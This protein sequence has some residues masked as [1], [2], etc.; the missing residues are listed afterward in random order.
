MK[1]YDPKQE[2]KHITNLDANKFYGY[3]MFKF[4]STSGFKCI[5]PKEFG[6]SKYTS[7]SSR[8]YVHE[9]N[10]KYPKELRNYTMIIC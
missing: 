10:L 7:N 4:L 6:L 5:N 9:V 1:S 8:R 3:A 2:S